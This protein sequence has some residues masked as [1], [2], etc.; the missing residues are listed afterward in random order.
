MTQDINTLINNSNSVGIVSHDP[1]G[2]NILN[3]LV[4]EFKDINFNLFVQG[5]AKLIFDAI[6]I[7]I[8]EDESTFFNSVD[9]VLFGTGSTSYEKKFLRYAKSKN[10]LTAAILDHFVNFRE[11]FIEGSTLSFPDHCFVC[12]EYSYQLAKKELFPYENISICKNYLVAAIQ[13]EIQTSTR[14]KNHDTVLYVLENVNEEWDDALLPWEI[15]FNNFYEN[16]YKDSDFKKI[17]VRPHP[18][19]NPKIYDSLK[20]YKEIIFDNTSSFIVA[21]SKVSTVVGIESYLLYVS[22]HCGL[23]VYTSI[24]KKIRSPRLPNH[25]FKRFDT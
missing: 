23:N 4:K 20:K 1:G 19:D 5:P 18:N 24:P 21:L 16:F 17:I 12:D 8:F 2:A 13:N 22:H 6:N 3:A 14:I 7:N 9:F 15:A 25:V 11:R 10:I